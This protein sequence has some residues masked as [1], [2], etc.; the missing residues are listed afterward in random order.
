M[1]RK[2]HFTGSKNQKVSGAMSIRKLHM[3]DDYMR[4]LKFNPPPVGLGKRLLR[5][6]KYGS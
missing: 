5:T 2:T 3:A 1:T 4:Y 6:R